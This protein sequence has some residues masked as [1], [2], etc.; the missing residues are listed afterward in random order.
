MKWSA[1]SSAIDDLRS[2]TILPEFRAHH[3]A[4]ARMLEVG[5]RFYLPADAKLIEGKRHADLFD[6]YRL[7][8]GCTVVLSCGELVDIQ[9]NVEMIT[10][11]L[12]VDSVEAQQ[13]QD[14]VDMPAGGWL[15]L[16][17]IV[18]HPTRSMWTLGATVIVAKCEITPGSLGVKM[19]ACDDPISRALAEALGNQ[20]VLEG[21]QHDLH[22]I[23]NLCVMLGMKNVET[24]HM[25]A[26]KLVNEKRQRKGKNLLLDYHVLKVD[27]ECWDARERSG[28]S[29]STGFRAHLR[30]GHIRNLANGRRTW[31]RAA[32]VHGCIDGF[33]TKDYEMAK[34]LEDRHAH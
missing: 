12:E 33:V 28:S 31:V 3:C 15:F 2:A 6:L 16:T 14:P 11:A 32:Y 13:L 8:F 24:E 27:G 1:F 20:H 25:K 34:S 19:Y 18:L 30:R 7:P 9:K 29:S 10:I 22:A 23:T 26:P 4:V 17:S 5:Q 21:M